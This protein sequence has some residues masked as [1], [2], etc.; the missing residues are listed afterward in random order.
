MHL[1][2]E[3]VVSRKINVFGED[4]EAVS[5]G[6]YVLAEHVAQQAGRQVQQGS[7][8]STGSLVSRTCNYGNTHD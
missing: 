5:S 7:T 6:A 1:C 2:K 8:P 4:T 3:E